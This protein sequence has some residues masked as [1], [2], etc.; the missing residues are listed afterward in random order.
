MPPLVVPH[1][2]LFAVGA[3][4]AVLNPGAVFQVYV[5]PAVKLVSLKDATRVQEVPQLVET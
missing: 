3:K 5:P 2:W 1:H 4:R